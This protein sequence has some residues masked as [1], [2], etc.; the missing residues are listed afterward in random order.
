AS[1][2]QGSTTSA[3]R[4]ARRAL[5]TVLAPAADA[6]TAIARPIPDDA[7]TTIRRHPSS[8]RPRLITFFPSGW[9][10]LKSWRVRSCR[11]ARACADLLVRD[12]GAP[13]AVTV[14]P[15]PVV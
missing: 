8:E 11:A 2:P 5:R 6:L 9:T 1:D 13:A 14:T 10:A 7:P 3:R 4:S 12:W 15:D